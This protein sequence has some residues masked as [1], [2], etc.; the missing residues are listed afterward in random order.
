MRR[1]KGLVKV[2]LNHVEAQITRSGFSHECVGVG[3]VAVQEPPLTVNNPGNLFDASLKE[4]QGIGICQ[5]EP[6]DISGHQFLEMIDVY[7]AF[8]IGAHRDGLETAQGAGGRIGAMSG[9]RD[10]DLMAMIPSCFK[11]F[12]YHHDTG[13]LSMGPRCRLK[14]KVGHAEN[15]AQV[16]SEFIH[17]LQT[18]L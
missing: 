16:F 1:G 14:G 7:T 10:Q 3:A 4:S 18:A 11:V 6:G 17:Q 12:F 13:Q 15:L 2:Q 8:S 9:I 5:H